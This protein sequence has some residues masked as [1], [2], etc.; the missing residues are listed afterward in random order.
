MT[1]LITYMAVAMVTVGLILIVQPSTLLPYIQERSSSSG[2]KWFAV[3]IR[4]AIGVALILVASATRFPTVIT[5]IGA[6]ALVAALLV[7]VMPL[8][9]FTQLVNRVAS[10]SPILAR[11]GGVATILAGAFIAWAVL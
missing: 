8:A 7:A 1:T 6:L 3:V 10:M 5:V 2:F 4:A 11:L 9:S